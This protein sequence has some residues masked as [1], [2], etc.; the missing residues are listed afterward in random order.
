VNQ[1]LPRWARR[2]LPAGLVGSYSQPDW[3]V[4]RQVL[5]ERLP[6]RVRAREFW[7]ID[8]PDLEDAQRRA[9][10]MALEDQVAAGV[11]VVT[12][13]EIRRE[14]Y[15]NRF[16]T[17][18]EG[19]DLDNHGVAVDRTGQE[20]PVPRVTGPIVWTG[21]A[22]RDY[23]ALLK[24]HTDLP[25]KVTLPGPFTMTQQAQNDYY[26]DEESL[27][28]AY[29]V[30]VNAEMK[31]LFDAGADIVQLDEP[32]VQA[33]PD[34]ARAYAVACINRALAGATGTTALHVCFGYGRHVEDKPNRYGFLGELDACRADEI[35]I[36][37]AQP[38]LD[39]RDLELLP[40]KY[41]HVG[42]ID[43]RDIE[44]E[45]PETVAKRIRAALRHLPPE[46]IVV[47][48]DCG[49]KYLTPKVARGKLTSM[50]AGR[51]LVLRELGLE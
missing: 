15:S 40:D 37:C 21:S 23:V 8:P 27:A 48:P 5:A 7:R 46:R 16:A 13:G 32:Y 45:S 12:D 20:V 38:Q 14:S 17:S 50:V 35:S 30:A 4:H 6:P 33:R 44:V 25:V 51:N 1:G 42:V 11:D 43:L 31:T 29:A 2:P 41:V 24:E 28:D 3:L 18:L 10:L 47:A 36:E 34:Q 26:A 49:M 9:T 39:L 22:E 19:I